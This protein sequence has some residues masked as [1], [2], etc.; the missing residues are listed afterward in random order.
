M[1]QYFHDLGSFLHFQDNAIL[2]QI[3]FL[4]PKWATNAVYK[5]VDT[6]E[7]QMSFG[8]F[9]FKQLTNIWKEYPEDKHIHLLEL[10]KKFEICFQIP[11][12][13]EYIIPELLSTRRP[14]FNWDDTQNLHFQYKYDFMPAGILTRFIVRVHDL[15][16][17]GIYWKNGVTIQR[18]NT[19]ALV[20]SEPLN[21]CIKIQIRGEDKRAMLAVIRREID[22]IHNTLN[23]PPVAT[24][25][26]CVCKVCQMTNDPYLH[27]FDYLKKAKAR[28]KLTVECKNSFE[29]V[30]IDDIL[31]EIRQNK[32]RQQTQITVYGDYYASRISNIVKVGHLNINREYSEE[33]ALLTGINAKQF[34]KIVTTLAGLS[35]ENI[36]KLED[37]AST[38]TAQPPEPVISEKIKVFAARNG[39]LILQSLP[40]SALYD[41]IKYLFV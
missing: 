27:D 12:T 4:D 34:R 20:I 38:F 16:K 24:L 18:E 8:R 26:P 29:D 23:N 37:L 28:R 31:G 11:D 10:M 41:F 15:N 2:K 40:A 21:R 1:S 5:I 3:V 25:L 35:K 13:D 9:S 22:Y 36:N 30:Y 6:K 39:V 7:V 33:L 19:Y 32:E 14:D 17:G